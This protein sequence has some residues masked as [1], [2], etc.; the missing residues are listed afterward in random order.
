MG[1]SPTNAPTAGGRPHIVPKAGPRPVLRPPRPTHRYSGVLPPP[2]GKSPGPLPARSRPRGLY[3]FVF[4][5]IQRPAPFLPVVISWIIPET[6]T[7][8]DPLGFRRKAFPPIFSRRRSWQRR[9]TSSWCR[10]ELSDS[11]PLR[12]HHGGGFF[13]SPP[14]IVPRR[15]GA[16]KVFLVFSPLTCRQ[17]PEN[18]PPVKPFPPGLLPSAPCG[19]GL[20][21]VFSSRNPDVAGGRF[22]LSLSPNFPSRVSP[23]A[24]GN[25]HKHFGIPPPP[26]PLRLNA[27]DGFFNCFRQFPVPPRPP[28]DPAG[29]PGPKNPTPR[30][31]EFFQTLR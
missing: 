9:P 21:C 10:T 13:L 11:D 16:R 23:P 14:S 2:A 31:P 7:H 4:V 12:L 3:F 24:P 18:A 6:K 20:L 22:R 28:P 5:L 8:R 19:A 15:R 29:C 27:E 17:T 25:P 1:K 26:R 30:G